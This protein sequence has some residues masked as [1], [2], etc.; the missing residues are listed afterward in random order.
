MGAGTIPSISVEV[1]LDNYL[2]SVDA[3]LFKIM[4]NIGIPLLSSY[5]AAQIFEAIGIGVDAMEVAF[6]GCVSRVG[7]ITLADI[8]R[9]RGGLAAG[10]GLPR[11]PG[12]VAH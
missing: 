3:G 4:S 5:H 1:A 7:G 6:K 8:A 9:H 10:P 2:K 11:D 12:Q